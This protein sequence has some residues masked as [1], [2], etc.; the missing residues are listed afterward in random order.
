[1]N[2]YSKYNINFSNISAE[3]TIDVS[4]WSV[5]ALKELLE[6]YDEDAILEIYAYEHFPILSFVSPNHEQYGDC[7]KMRKTNLGQFKHKVGYE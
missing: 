3:D 5:S 6:C 7:K 2:K 4:F 1:M